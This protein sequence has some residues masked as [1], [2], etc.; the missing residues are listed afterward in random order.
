MNSR[1]CLR[2]YHPFHMHYTYYAYV[3]VFIYVS[4]LK[5]Y[6]MCMFLFLFTCMGGHV[7]LMGTCVIH[8]FPN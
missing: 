8:I 3:Y 6:V 2:V 5:V 1:V 7:G 4:T